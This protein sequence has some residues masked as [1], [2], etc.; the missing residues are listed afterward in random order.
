MGVSSMPDKKFIIT[1]KLDS[2]EDRS[3]TLTIRMDRTL[4]DKSEALANQTNRSRNEIICM[5]LE[6]AL[7]NIE[8]RKSDEK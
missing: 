8:I 6:F 1:P 4:Q 7:D 2:K 5:A 3:V